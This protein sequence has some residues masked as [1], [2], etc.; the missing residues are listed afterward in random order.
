MS[1]GTVKQITR[2]KIPLAKTKN[3]LGQHVTDTEINELSNK[4]KN[5]NKKMQS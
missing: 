3:V 1:N 4:S 5:H 2:V